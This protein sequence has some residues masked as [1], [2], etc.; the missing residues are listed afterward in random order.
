MASFCVH[1]GKEY[2]V[3]QRKMYCS[4]KCTRAAAK[5]RAMLRGSANIKSERGEVTPYRWKQPRKIETDADQARLKAA[6][7]AKY[8]IG[9]GPVVTLQRWTPEWDEA[10]AAASRPGQGRK[11][12]PLVGLCCA[13]KRWI[14]MRDNRNEKYVRC[15]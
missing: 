6:I 12:S 9:N 7:D 14:S 2:P 1:C 8:G 15:K 5:K 10:V 11:V 13:S 3:K 4:D